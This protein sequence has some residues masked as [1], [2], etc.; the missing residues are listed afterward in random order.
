MTDHQ[1]T[2]SDDVPGV[3]PRWVFRSSTRSSSSCWPLAFRWAST[4]SSPFAAGRAACL[5]PRLWRSSRSQA[6]VGSG[7]PGA[8]SNGRAICA[9]PDA[10]PS[11]C[12]AGKK[13][14]VRP[15]WTRHSALSSFATSSVR[16]R[17]AYRSVPG[18][19]ALSMGSI[20]TVRW[21]RPRVGVSS[22][23]T[24][25][26]EGRCRSRGSGL[27]RRLTDPAYNLVLGASLLL[28]FVCAGGFGG[29]DAL[30]L[31]AVGAWRGWK[32]YGEEVLAGREAALWLREKTL[33]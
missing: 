8:R 31:G 16:S 18:S 19:F 20:S 12:A 33:T 27:A 22:N 30:V 29:G 14:Y 13:K 26:D 7:P 2:M 23:S 15:S 24:H 6:G 28:H 3:P 25:F 32:V 9:L 17:E 4:G 10:R 5:A 21:K 1:G 11:P